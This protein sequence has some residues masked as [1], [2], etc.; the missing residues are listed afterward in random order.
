[1][2]T[3][4]GSKNKSCRTSTLYV[5]DFLIEIDLTKKAPFIHER[6]KLW[7]MITWEV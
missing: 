1:M 3:P 2:R 4:L 6:K 7:H 5:V